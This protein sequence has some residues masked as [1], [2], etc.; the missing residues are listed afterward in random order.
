HRARCETTRPLSLW[1]LTVL[2]ISWRSRPSLGAPARRKT[3]SSASAF[4]SRSE[5]KR[6]RASRGL[7]AASLL[8]SA[9]I[10]AH[11]SLFSIPPRTCFKGLLSALKQIDYFVSTFVECS[12]L[13]HVAFLAVR[14]HHH[15]EVC[16]TQ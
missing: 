6:A 11:V 1:F 5:V 16:F 12:S 8:R 7:S 9:K 2:A 13:L 3:S 4:E 10:A 14:V 15:D